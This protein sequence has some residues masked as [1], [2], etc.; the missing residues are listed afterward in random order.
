MN[1]WLMLGF[2]LILT[3]GTGFFVASEFSLV[4][5]ERS[6]L[7][8]RQERGEKGLSNSIRALSRTSTH[9][10]GAQLGITLTTMLTGFLVEPSLTELLQPVLLGLGV[11]QNLTGGVGLIVGMFL[12]TLFSTLIGELVPKKLA[13]TLPLQ[14]NKFVVGFQLAFTWI[15]SGMIFILNK[16]GNG[17]VRSIGIEP[18]EELSSTRTAEELT[19]L[20]RRSASL[21]ALDA[22][23][24][25]LLTK[26]LALSQLVAAD[27]MTPRPRMHVLDKDDSLQR[28]IEA[29]IKTGH[30][31]FPISD[32]TADD[33]IGVAHVKQA[34]AV[35][36]EKR[37]E[38][39]VS[40]IMVEALRVPETMRLETLMVELR[41]KGLQLAIVVDEYGGTAGLAT[42]EDLVEELVGEL[43]DEHDRAKAGV[44]RGA[45]SSVLFPGM[46]RPDELL[47]M[48]IKVPADG[49]YETV[50]GFMMS[51]LGRI[52]SVGDQ[53]E[54]E[55]GVLR[56]ERMDGRRVDRV[57]FTPTSAQ[58]R[59][60]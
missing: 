41:A 55:D 40:A 4:N 57:R 39:P 51:E 20:V 2:G 42:L 48:A 19:S 52:P 38:V 18:K 21:G 5:L 35:P 25:T 24:A 15:F 33:I 31:R 30:S 36:R 23:T 9:L 56:V 37:A 54:I 27:V 29:S 43:A 34:A 46:I 28:L 32:G 10:S 45:N 53:V 6:D 17:I 13:L 49:A 7:E 14:V 50:A 58:E 12:A 60:E 47:E 26:T 44:T 22:Q 3:I 16:V 59:S 8:A 11:S 1:E